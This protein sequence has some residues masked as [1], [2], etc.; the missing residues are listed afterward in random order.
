MGIR[1]AGKSRVKARCDRQP[2]I[3]SRRR[4][5]SIA[6]RP[7]VFAYQFDEPTGQAFL[8]RRLFALSLHTDYFLLGRPASELRLPLQSVVFLIARYSISS[9]RE[10]ETFTGQTGDAAADAVADH[11]V[12]TATALFHK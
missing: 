2:A 10:L 8:L 1:L 11:L 4:R 5:G 9:A 7:A 6:V 3:H 12:Q